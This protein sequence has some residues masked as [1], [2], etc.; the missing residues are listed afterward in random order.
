[1]YLILYQAICICFFLLAFIALFNPLRV[2]VAANRW[3]GL[4]FASVGCMI[5]NAILF[6][7]G[8]ARGYQRLIAFNELSRYAMA[9]ALYLSIMQFTTPDRTIKLKDGLHFIPFFIFFVFMAPV[10]FVPGYQIGHFP[11]GVP[12][13]IPQIVAAMVIITARAQ[14]VVYWILSYY[15]LHQHRKHIQ[16]VVSDMRPVDL[17]W[18]KYLLWGIG[19]ML[20]QMYVLLL[21]NI[22][23]IKIYPALI[24]LAAALAVL[25][26]SLAQ[27][28]IYPFAPTELTAINQ[29]I[30]NA[31]RKFNPSKQR[32]P[33]EQAQLLQNRLKQLMATDK[34]YLDNELSLPQLAESISVS[35][36]DLSYLLNDR[37]G[38]NFFEFVNTYR[39]E[40]AKQIMLDDKY[41]HLNILGVAFNSGFNSKTTFNTVFKKQTGLSP[42]QFIQ[43]AKLKGQPSVSLPG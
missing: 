35:V 17:N 23:P 4:F 43:Q 27:K 26:Y 28:E 25:Y 31:D 19:V 37:M 3:L 33:D 20:L 34:L 2:N 36:H 32:I 18:L 12:R 42:S 24:Y 7:S 14:L 1:M 38:V 5:V 9:P 13:I 40:E 10:A 11:V 6:E 39:V 16:L 41:K 8:V 22:H 15:Q 30:E 21:F 29:V